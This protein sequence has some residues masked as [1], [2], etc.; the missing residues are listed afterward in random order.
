MGEIYGR[1]RFDQRFRKLEDDVRRLRDRVR[2]TP[3]PSGGE[4]YPPTVHH[5]PVL[6]PGIVQNLGQEVR[7]TEVL[8]SL[9]VLSGVVRPSGVDPIT[10]HTHLLTL[11]ESLRVIPPRI[12]PVSAWESW[13]VADLTPGQI[14]IYGTSDF[15]R[16]G[17]VYWYST[18][19][20]ISI[21]L[22]GATYPLTG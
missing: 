15:D 2:E 14:L 10:E 5:I 19:P 18:T 3:T 22:D 6:A 13:T 8:E 4:G 17:Q 12:I 7:A 1:Q 11:P 9:V 16:P 21:H 20:V